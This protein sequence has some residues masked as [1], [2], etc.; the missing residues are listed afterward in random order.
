M[1]KSVLFLSLGFTNLAIFSVHNK[2]VLMIIIL[3]LINN[4]SSQY[5]WCLILEEI[6]ANNWLEI[7]AKQY[8]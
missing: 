2:V 1:W 7:N 4:F 6:Q 5:L 8:Y 3:I